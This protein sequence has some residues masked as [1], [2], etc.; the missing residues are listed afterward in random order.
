M[1]IVEQL[2]TC[3]ASKSALRNQVCFLIPILAFLFIFMFALR[4]VR[5]TTNVVRLVRYSTT[6][7]RPKSQDAR[8]ML[9]D[10][11]TT[12]VAAANKGQ[13]IKALYLAAK[14]KSS[15]TAPS[16]TIY[17]ALMSLAAR[18]QSW[19]FAWA[20]F[21]DMHH[22]G[23]QPTTTTYAHLLQVPSVS[24]LSGLPSLTLLE[25]TRLNNHGLTR[26]CGLFSNRFTNMGSSSIRPCIRPL[27]TSSSSRETLR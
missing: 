3:D 25:C 23:V 5:C 2:P 4:G 16:I 19:L 24:I 10:H 21:D 12:I 8:Q 9:T 14:M 27:S 1:V 7:T 22:C 18:E 15:P 17:N 13:F 11:S 6:T 26:I 20:I